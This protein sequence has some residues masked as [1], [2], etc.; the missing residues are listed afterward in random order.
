MSKQIDLTQPLSDEDRE[1]LRVLGRL[2]DIRRNDEQF[3]EGYEAPEA[4]EPSATA[5]RTQAA[6]IGEG[7][8]GTRAAN[9]SQPELAGEGA[10][11]VGD[12]TEAPY[13][14]WN[15]VDLREELEVRE[16]SK[17]GNKGE[18]AARLREDDAARMEEG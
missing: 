2:D 10:D 14:E 7:T 17:S 11:E 12:D 13:E 18:L 6:G 15:L 3:A 5:D 1:Y 4:R 8:L 16:L 9:A